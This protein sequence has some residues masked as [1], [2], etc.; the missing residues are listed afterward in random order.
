[1]SEHKQNTLLLDIK[2]LLTGISEQTLLLDIK[3]ILANARPMSF[4][5]QKEFSST[6]I[7]LLSSI[8]KLLL[9]ILLFGILAV[10]IFFFL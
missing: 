2:N 8:K 3:N 10:S 4:D 5:E 6:A 9:G 1:M 7:K